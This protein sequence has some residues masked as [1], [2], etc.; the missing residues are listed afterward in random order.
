M[1]AYL[2]Q[3][4]LFTNEE[5]DYFLS[6]GKP[7]TLAKGDYFIREGETANKIAYVTSGFL[8]NFYYSSQS[9][10]VTYCL[11]F[12]NDLITA[13]S[14][15]ITQEQSKENIQ[16]LWDC[17]LIEFS[18]QDID[19]LVEANKSWLLFT[20]QIAESQYIKLENRI[21]MLQKESALTRYKELLS[22]HAE[23]LQK[24]PLGYLASYLGISQRHLSRL[25]K[26][27]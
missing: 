26:Q 18:K 15:L 22:K 24:I 7:S 5:I 2:E 23:Y 12:A 4:A 27:I 21:F 8:R 11:S 6:L 1:K 10:E 3:T 25:R 20:K 13:Y 9:E 19:Q 16:A 17:E 14:S